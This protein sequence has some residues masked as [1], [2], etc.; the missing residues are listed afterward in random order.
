MKKCKNE[1]LRLIRNASK[2]SR[3]VQNS[4]DALPFVRTGWP[5]QS[6][7]KENSAIN[8]DY[9]VISVYS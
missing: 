5:D 7:P 6:S 4:Q 1:T 8:Q 3:P 9:P 2:I